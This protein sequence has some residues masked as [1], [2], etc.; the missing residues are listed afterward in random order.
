MLDR[1]A[2]VFLIAL[3]V[4]LALTALF[5][6]IWV[7]PVLPREWLAGTPFADYTIPA[8]ALGMIG[9]GA[10][11]SVGLLAFRPDWGVMLTLFVGAAMSMFEVVETLVVGLDVW[12]Y[13]L[14]LGPQP[15][16]SSPSLAGTADMGALLGVVQHRPMLHDQ[17]PLDERGVG[18]ARCVGTG[19]PR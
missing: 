6:A 5:G 9:V 15:A 7:V 16:P 17:I 2:R 4:F 10:C 13:A 8:L 3:H 11:I 19:L 1:I 18:R 14:H 12:L